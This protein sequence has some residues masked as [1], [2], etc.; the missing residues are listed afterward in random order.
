MFLLVG[1]FTT[2]ALSAVVSAYMN[3]NIRFVHASYSLAAIVSIYSKV[4]YF[5]NI[6]RSVKRFFLIEKLIE[7]E[8]NEILNG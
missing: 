4:E 1:S 7:K 3:L 5:I 6:Y 2:Q 8:N